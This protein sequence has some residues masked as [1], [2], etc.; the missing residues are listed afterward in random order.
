MNDFLS[1]VSIAQKRSQ[2]LAEA[3]R[4]QKQVDNGYANI[5]YDQIVESINAFDEELDNEHEV[6]IKLVSFGQT[7]QF[8]ITQLKYKNPYLIYFVGFL[9]D[10]SPIELV[11][12][13]SQISFVMIKLKR[14]ETET[15]KRKIGFAN[16]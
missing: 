3:V 5:F 2:A 6:G 1:Q 8:H 4:N 9:E 10:G 11:Q 16:E 7:I 12:N 15:P 13:V 14:A